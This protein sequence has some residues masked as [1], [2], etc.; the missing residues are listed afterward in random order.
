VAVELAE[1]NAASSLIALSTFVTRSRDSALLQFQP[2]FVTDLALTNR[3]LALSHA[4]TDLPIV[5]PQVDFVAADDA[6]PSPADESPEARLR[7]ELEALKDLL[8][9]IEAIL[10]EIGPG[11]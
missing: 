1:E 4:L 7:A 8:A 9:R 11:E 10:A 3:Q 5:L 6:Q 2:S